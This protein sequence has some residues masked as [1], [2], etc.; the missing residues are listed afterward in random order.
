MIM[1]LIQQVRNH[2]VKV[3]IVI[4]FDEACLVRSLDSKLIFLYLDVL[5]R[6]PAG[7]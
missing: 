6:A 1:L 7:K 2:F 4:M 3:V 5:K